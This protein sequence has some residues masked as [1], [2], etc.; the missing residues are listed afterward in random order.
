M[1]FQN[2][3]GITITEKDTIFLKGEKKKIPPGLCCACDPCVGE[4]HD[5]F[6]AKASSDYQ[7]QTFLMNFNVFT[8]GMKGHGEGVLLAVILH[9]MM[10]PTSNSTF[11][12]TALLPLLLLS[13]THKPYLK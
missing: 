8:V 10:F 4:S 13:G 9:L 6:L 7:Q 12:F 1:L 11:G 3:Q 2:L 5:E